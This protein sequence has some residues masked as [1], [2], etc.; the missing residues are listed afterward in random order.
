MDIHVAVLEVFLLYGPKIGDA[1]ERTFWRARFARD[2]WEVRG[3]GEA[4]AV[5]LRERRNART[6]IVVEWKRL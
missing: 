5:M 6:F 3:V 1:S 4:R 2:L